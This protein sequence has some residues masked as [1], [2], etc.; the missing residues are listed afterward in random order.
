NPTPQVPASGVM[1]FDAKTVVDAVNR[2]NAFVA[3]PDLS[4][5]V[6]KRVQAGGVE[7]H[8]KESDVF[9]VLDGE[10]TFVTGGTLEGGRSTRP[11]QQMG[12]A[13]SGGDTYH[14]AKGDVIV[15]EAGVPHWFKEVPQ[16]IP[17]YVV[18]SI[19]PYQA[20]SPYFV[21]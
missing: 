2:P 14:L 5:Q 11:G 10:A 15:V 17:Y 7:V 4:V 3:A 20:P 19:R 18:K 9:Y 16:S 13:I 6:N 1:Y 12:S 8:D 21:D